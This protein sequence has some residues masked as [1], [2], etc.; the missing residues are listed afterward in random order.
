MNYKL[1]VSIISIGVIIGTSSS[2]VFKFQEKWINYRTTCETLKKEWYYYK[3]GIYEYKESENLEE[4]FVERVENLISR[5]NT[6][7]MTE[8]EE[9]HNI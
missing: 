9:K 5:E 4:L 3:S 1:L 8:S 6:Y 7:W 2:K